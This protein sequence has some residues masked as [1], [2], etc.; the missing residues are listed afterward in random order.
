MKIR[1]FQPSDYDDL[2]GMYRAQSATLPRHHSVRR[3]QFRK[4]LFTT[5]FIRNPADHHDKARVALVAQQGQR[6]TAFVS[7]GMVVNGDEVVPGGTAYIQAI[8]AEPSA[9]A[10][11]RQLLSRVV[12]H[13]R[14]YR[15]KQIV[16]HDGCMCPV[17][18]S[19]GASALPSQWAWIGQ[20]LLDSGFEVSDRLLRLAAELKSTRR[21]VIPPDNLVMHHL[22]HEMY[23][24][25]PKYDFGC[26]LLKPPYEYGCG[27]VWCG[28]FYSGAFVKG[29][30]YRSLYMNYFT[31]LDDA[32]RGQGLG[33]L[34]LQHC[35]C[36]AR[37]RG[38]KYAS[39][40]TDVDNL[41]AQNLYQ[42]E[43]FE[44]ID[45]MHSFRFKMR[46]RS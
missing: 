14:R 18:Y 30:A 11:V 1:P 40:L 45:A 6:I 23:G 38:A 37:R 46:R 12:A 3:D 39:L 4:D 33:R 29:T 27:V 20:C 31:I 22:T 32:Y 15:P 9:A 34:V 44:V 5:R 17:F 41:V 16:A 13:L 26:I 19:D 7:G 25:D 24:F 35:L 36:E 8:I 21:K 2:F 28:N 43:G 10:A 42:S